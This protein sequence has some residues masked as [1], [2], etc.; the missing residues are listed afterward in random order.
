MRLHT[1]EWKAVHFPDRTILKSD[2]DLFPRVDW[3][4]LIYDIEVEPTETAGHYR[5]KETV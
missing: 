5:A 1:E 2:R 4:M 3:E